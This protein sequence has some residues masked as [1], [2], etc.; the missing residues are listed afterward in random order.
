VQLIVLIIIYFQITFHDCSLF[1]FK[2]KLVGCPRYA[3]GSLFIFIKITVKIYN[4]KN[5]I[6]L[7]LII[8]FFSNLLIILLIIL[9]IIKLIIFITQMIIFLIFIL[10]IIIKIIIFVTQI[11]IFLIW[12]LWIIERKNNIFMSCVTQF[13]WVLTKDFK[14]FNFYYDK[15]IIIKCFYY[16]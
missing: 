1:C 9:I 11:T 3:L 13:Y 16:N 10:L 15:S 12:T 4:I 2:M 7:I 8:I 14:Y 5:N 6:F